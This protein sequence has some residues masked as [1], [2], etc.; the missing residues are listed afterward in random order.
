VRLGQLA[1]HP[2]VVG[3]GAGT[4]SAVLGVLGLFVPLL[5]IVGVV[6]AVVGIVR[7]RAQIARQRAGGPGAR[8]SRRLWVGLA[9]G[10]LAVAIVA[11]AA[12]LAGQPAIG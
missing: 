11:Y 1:G 2:G 8:L 5:G 3:A 10:L 9:L 6:V 12:G 7:G 4:W